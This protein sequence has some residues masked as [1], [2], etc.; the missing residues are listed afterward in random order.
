MLFKWYIRVL[1]IGVVVWNLGWAV[2]STVLS[3]ANV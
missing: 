2:V 1:M 3:L